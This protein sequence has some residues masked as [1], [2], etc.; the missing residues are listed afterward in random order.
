[1]SGTAVS[2]PRRRGLQSVAPLFVDLFERY[3]PDPFVLAIILTAV[4]A[5]L[6]LLIAPKGSPETIVSTWYAGIFAILGFAFQM[7][8]ILATGHA[9][10]HAPI[11]ERLLHRLVALARTP[12]QAVVLTFLVAAAASLLNWGFG[13]VVGAILA[14]EVARQVRV[15]FGWLVAA[16]YS[17]FVVWASGISSSIALTQASHGNA[18]NIVEKLTG[19]LLPLSDTVFATFNWV[20]TLL[21]VLLMPIVFIAIRPADADVNAFVPEPDAPPPPAAVSN[22]P[23]RRMDR[24]PM[25]SLFL[26][27]AGL[28]AVL[29]LWLESKLAL[30]VNMVILIFLIAGIGLHGSPVAYGAAM[31]NAARQT[32]GMM[33]QY[34]FYGGIM[35]IMSGTGLADSISKAFVAVSSDHTLPFWSYICSLIITFFVPSGGGHWAVQGPFVVPAAVTLHASMAGSAMAVAM[36]EQVANMLQPFWALPVVAMAGIGIQRVMGYTVVT[37]VVTGVIY[38]AAL[39]L[40]I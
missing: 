40:L 3:M 8:L 24:S 12:N 28:A 17:G 4:T 10:A 22:T 6:A 35:G 11:V 21:I 23:A 13:L 25:G 39:L 7:I 15:D 32:G 37:F 5:I 34:P 20:P 26:V 16:A 38:A 27:A 9:L 19:Q 14:R 18:L 1:M 31:K 30:D 2:Q 33:L 29:V 36:G